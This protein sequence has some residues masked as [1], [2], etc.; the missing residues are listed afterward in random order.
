[1]LKILGEGLATMQLLQY[2]IFS[3]IM[4]NLDCL[5][6]VQLV[7]DLEHF[8]QFKNEQIVCVN[9]IY[10]IFLATLLVDDLEHFSH[11]KNE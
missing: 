1:M 3:S 8:S 9:S 4:I 7:D 5:T 11:F 10:K 2:I 6:P